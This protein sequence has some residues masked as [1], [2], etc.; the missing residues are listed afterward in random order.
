M[1]KLRLL[2]LLFLLSSSLSAQKAE[3]LLFTEDHEAISVRLNGELLHSNPASEIRIT[4]LKDDYYKLV[5]VFQNKALGE[6]S[7]DLALQQGML[8]TYGIRKN[9]NGD[10]VLR[11]ISQLPLSEAEKSSSTQL[12]IAYK[13]K[14]IANAAPPISKAS[15]SASFEKDA[16]LSPVIHSEIDPQNNLDDAPETQNDQSCETVVI[17]SGPENSRS[18][19]P[20]LTATNYSGA[21]KC[22]RPDSAEFYSAL[23]EALLLK[24]DDA[25]RLKFVKNNL[26]GHCFYAVQVRYLCEQFSFEDDRLEIAKAAYKH[27]YDIGNYP[28]IHDVF[29]FETT[30]EE[31][32][33][34][35]SSM[36]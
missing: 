35:I 31:L 19:L 17:V 32:N 8:T 1:I 21:T 23:V 24:K 15:E 34:F 29:N 36:N 5:L 13:E 28:V 33:A 14:A 7:F 9:H 30:I 12:L 20:V 3:V 6:K 27:T 26:T 2:S 22:S 16:E 18:S 10:Y 25:E 11:F 4:G